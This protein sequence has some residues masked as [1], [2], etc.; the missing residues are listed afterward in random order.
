[1]LQIMRAN[2]AW[3]KKFRLRRCRKHTN[4]TDLPLD[5]L[6]NILTRLPVKSLYRI[7]RL[8]KILKNIVDDQSFVTLHTQLLTAT[9]AVAEVP[10]LILIN[11]I[12]VTSF[13]AVQLFEYDGNSSLE[14]SKR[15]VVSEIGL[16]VNPWSNRQ[17]VFCNL[18]FFTVENLSK[19]GSPYAVLFDPFKGEVLPLP[20]IDVQD[21]KERYGVYGMGFD[22][23]TSTHKIIRVAVNTQNNMEAQ[24]LVLG[25]SSWRKIPSVPPYLLS[26]STS[27]L[28]ANGDM[29]WLIHL[30]DEFSSKTESCI[31]SFDFKK[32]EFYCTPHPI[33]STRNMHL[34]ILSGCM[35]FMAI[36]GTQVEIWMLKNYE[37]KEWTREHTIDL[38][39]HGRTLEDYSRI[40]GCGQWEHGIFF[41]DSRRN[42][43]F[44]DLRCDSIKDVTYPVLYRRPRSPVVNIVPSIHSCTPGLI[45]LKHYGNVIDQEQML[46]G[47][48]NIWNPASSNGL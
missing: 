41:L 16:T 1:M 47:V 27:L 21:P 5:I 14:K 45:S 36:T 10:Q 3:L 40:A 20:M 4:L 26:T 13:A 2:I 43:L 28:S 11:N 12:G 17:F 38:L 9:N 18:F 32:E 7:R 24:V 6:V 39:V 48:N 35:A 34:F 29:H 31:I 42:A 44:F 46:F 23:L 37:R 19:Y 22:H 25:T 33:Q 30:V 15:A 8:S